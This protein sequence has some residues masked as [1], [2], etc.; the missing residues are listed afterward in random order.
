MKPLAGMTEFGFWMPRFL[1]LACI[2]W[3]V[4]EWLAG[5]SGLSMSEGHRAIPAW[6]M[7]EKGNWFA[8]SMFEQPYLR[9]PP[10]MPW[11]IAGMSYLL[12]QTELAA[13]SVS[14]I[15]MLCAACLSAWF[16]RRWFGNAA[17]FAAG[18]AHLLTPWF[19]E[20]GRAAEIEAL[21][22]L[23]VVMVIWGLI[24]QLITPARLGGRFASLAVFAVGI[25]IAGLAKGPAGFLVLC[26]TTIATLLIKPQCGDGKPIS[27]VLG[28]CFSA[29]VASAALIALGVVIW[30]RTHA[31]ATPPI[32]QSVTEFLWSWDRIGK[33]AVMPAT[34]LV[35]ALPLSLAAA[36]ASLSR[37]WITGVG[38]PR[39]AGDAARLVALGAFISLGLFALA[40]VSNPR[41]LLPVAATLSPIAGLAAASLLSGP[42]LLRSSVQSRYVIMAFTCVLLA[43]SVIYTI[44]SESS[45]RISSGKLAGIRL[46]DQ[47]PDGSVVIADDLVEARPEVL[48]YAARTAA[49]RGVNIR[50]IWTP[51]SI[52]LRRDTSEMAW[53]D[54]VSHALIR[55]DS[56]SS[57]SDRLAPT[58]KELRLVDTQVTDQVGPENRPFEFRMYK[59]NHK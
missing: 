10:G 25:L 46:A 55:T 37:V 42:L 16:A 11:A 2:A 29:C 34:V 33:I 19:W 12:G 3:L 13:R 27:R 52:Y 58:L 7:M 53:P 21:H 1:A 40:G 49:S 17:A 39:Q 43:G 54:G 59:R 4:Y 23:G 38:L 32:T 8:P 44:A 35:S 57:E 45:R 15:S 56:R 47:L 5:S 14:A 48:W 20:S 26:G 24:D 6:E 36:W 31:G 18:A 50:C 28:L 30:Q 41:Y 22:N 9:K 51:A